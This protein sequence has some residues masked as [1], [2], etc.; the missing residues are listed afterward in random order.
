MNFDLPLKTSLQVKLGHVTLES[1]AGA[2]LCPVTVMV[3]MCVIMVTVKM[4]VTHTGRDL[5][6]SCD[7]VRL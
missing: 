6:A 5:P 2:A 1:L 7:W 4:T 3:M